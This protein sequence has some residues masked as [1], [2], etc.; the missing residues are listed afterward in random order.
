MNPL[1]FFAMLTIATFLAA[2]GGKQTTPAE[3][4][5]SWGTQIEGKPVVVEVYRNAQPGA[6]WPDLI[7][8]SVASKETPFVGRISGNSF[9]GSPTGAAPNGI[10]GAGD[11]V[12]FEGQH[13]DA[14]MLV[15]VGIPPGTRLEPRP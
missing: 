15:G 7:R 5:G 10:S 12:R 13:L 4:V 2:C 8:V 11:L 3:K 9:V 14:E 6:E 1:R